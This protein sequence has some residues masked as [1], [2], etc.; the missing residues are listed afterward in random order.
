VSSLLHYLR[1][2][3]VCCA[4]IITKFWEE[5]L[6]CARVSEGVGEGENGIG[7]QASLMSLLQLLSST[8]YGNVVMYAR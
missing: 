4:V 5:V 1:Y 8:D 6:R 7:E 3:I 2:V